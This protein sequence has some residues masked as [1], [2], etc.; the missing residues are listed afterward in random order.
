MGGGSLRRRPRRPRADPR[1]R[2]PAPDGCARL[3]RRDS[4]RAREGRRG[5]GATGARLASGGRRLRGDASGSRSRPPGARPCVGGGRR[6][7]RGRAVRRSPANFGL[8]MVV[9]GKLRA[10][11]EHELIAEVDAA[12]VDGAAFDA[13]LTI[14]RRYRT[15]GGTQADAESALTVLMLRYR[16]QSHPLEDR[17]AD[18]LDRVVGWCAPDLRIW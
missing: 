7:G 8:V 1:R 9:D 16:S 14:V 15:A 3:P 11:T 2:T 13:L 4:A 12:I 6:G 17:V 10:M 5:A 18:L